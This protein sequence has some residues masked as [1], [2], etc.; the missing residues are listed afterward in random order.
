ML[1]RVKRS[2]RR[3]LLSDRNGPSVVRETLNKPK[4]HHK[5]SLIS[6]QEPW[7]L[8]V[9]WVYSWYLKRSLGLLNA[10]KDYGESW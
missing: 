3:L 10:L 8:Q 4:A 5:P 7:I 6:L 1:R 9:F 2:A